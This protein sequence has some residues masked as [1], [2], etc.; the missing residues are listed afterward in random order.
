[1]Q[2]FR[3]LVRGLRPGQII[4]LLTTIG[5]VTSILSFALS[6][7]TKQS[8]VTT[9]WVGCLQNFGTGM[10]SSAITFW[11]IDVIFGLRERKAQVIRAMKNK[12]SAPNA[13]TEA[14]EQGWFTDG[15]FE[16]VDLRNAQ[17]Q[18][19]I[20]PGANLRRADLAHA[21]LD[22]ANLFG[23]DLRQASLGY[24]ALCNAS[25]INAKLQSTRLTGCDLLEASLRGAE[26]DDRTIL[27]NNRRCKLGKPPD[28]SYFTDPDYPDGVWRSED[29]RSPAYRGKQSTPAENKSPDAEK[30]D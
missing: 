7:T 26:F 10:I 22:G 30:A 28:W 24:A 8:S 4:G 15:S 17:L 5:I 29:P 3:K 27:P 11:L 13:V 16:G 20:L 25:L 2:R 18:D 19:A 12:S 23:A 14:R 6:Q 1:M 9:W 21:N